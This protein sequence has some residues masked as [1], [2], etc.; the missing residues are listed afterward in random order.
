M[1]DLI[2][3]T[4]LVFLP[5]LIFEE[6][7]Y[8]LYTIASPQFFNFSGSRIWFDIAWFTASGAVSVI[9]VGRKRWFSLLPSFVGAGIFAVSTYIAPLC[10][11]KECYI[12]STDGLG[13]FRD[14][15]LFA[16]LGF[17]ASNAILSE[18]LLSTL[19]NETKFLAPYTLFGAA[20]LGYAL[21]FFPMVHIF[22]G[23][24]VGYPVNYVQ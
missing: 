6:Y 8:Y 5:P 1:L 16:S 9:I 19:G 10:F 22:A 15:L 7:T 13:S 20:L 2:A 12:S 21:S 23:I 18:K 4:L 11:E 14:F 17:L 3:A 24:T